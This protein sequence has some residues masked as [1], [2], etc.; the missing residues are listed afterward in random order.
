MVFS[1]RWREYVVSQRMARWWRGGG[2]PRRHLVGG[3]TDAAALHLE[4]GPGVL[5]G[6][7]EGGHGVAAR[8]LLH[9][10][11]GGVDDA[12]G[13]V[14]LPRERILLTTWVTRTER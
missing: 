1:R 8:L 2:A 7:L 6:A 9:L 4:L 3:A 14:R 10:L 13:Q 5:H 11:E 12:L